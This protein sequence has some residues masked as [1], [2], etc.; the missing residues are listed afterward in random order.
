MLAKY[1]ILNV[2][3]VNDMIDLD[4]LEKILAKDDI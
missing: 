3:S 1:D 2:E 4:K